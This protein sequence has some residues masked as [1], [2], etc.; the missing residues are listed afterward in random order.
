MRRMSLTEE[1]FTLRQMAGPPRRRTGLVVAFVI[2]AIVLTAAAT[3]GVMYAMSG[4]NSAPPAAAPPASPVA[5][6]ITRPDATCVRT[7]GTDHQDYWN[8]NGWWAGRI[9]GT[10]KEMP[11][12]SVL[13]LKL[14]GHQINS[15]WICAPR[16]NG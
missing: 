2:G 1:P 14:N 4:G 9:D 12:L 11:A 10:P 7:D 15:V 3:A 6:G 8:G 13:S 16:A 5:D